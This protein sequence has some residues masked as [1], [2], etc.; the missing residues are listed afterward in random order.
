[1]HELLNYGFVEG[2]AFEGVM[3][4]AAEKIGTTGTSDAVVRHFG[5]DAKGVDALEVVDVTA[6]FN[7]EATES[8]EEGGSEVVDGE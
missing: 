3:P 5:C 4:A 8:I 7:S 1:M 2:T 6:A